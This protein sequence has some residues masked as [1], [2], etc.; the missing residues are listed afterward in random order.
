MSVPVETPIPWGQLIVPLTVQASEY[1]N[2]S[3][4]L[5]FVYQMVA[6]FD[7]AKTPEDTAFYASLLF[8]SFSLCE[9]LTIMHWARLSDR[10][11]RRPVIIIG[12]TGYLV[13]FVLFGSVVAEIS[14][15][16]NRARMMMLLPLTW[17]IG[18]VAGSAI[19]GIFADPVHQYPGLF[20]DSKLFRTFPY[21]LP[22][23]VG[24]STTVFGLGMSIFKFKESLVREPARKIAGSATP[25]PVPL[26]SELATEDTRL[27]SGNE[28]VDDGQPHRYTLRE[29][30]TPT[31]VKV[32]VT[33]VVIV[34]TIC[35]GEAVYPSF[36]ASDPNDGGLGLKPRGIGI[37]LAL[38][39]IAVMYL[40]LVTYPQMERKYGALKCYLYGQAVFIPFSLA[41]SFLTVLARHMEASVGQLPSWM[42]FTLV[43]AMFW[44]LLVFLLLIHAFG[45]VLAFASLTILAANLAPSRTELGFI[46]GLQQMGMSAMRTIKHDLSYPFN[47]HLVWV[48]CAV[49]AAVSLYIS[50]TIPTEVNT[51]AA[52]ELRSDTD[53]EEA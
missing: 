40:Q 20:G 36:A 10:I 4:I 44:I 50:Y 25:S 18:S 48:L 3:L 45:V 53:E 5:P 19:G 43:D 21:L 32:L 22:C 24:C 2:W 29:M 27:L 13:S 9:M 30:L 52:G 12:L 41:M 6:D 35:M 51:F 47:S 46:Y 16:T 37:S 17:N 14:D 8:S 1:L 34:L 42:Q 7:V 31:V 15:N 23:L 38:T 28:P 26:S 49:L 39:D 33:N 11:G